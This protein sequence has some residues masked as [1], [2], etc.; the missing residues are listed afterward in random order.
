[1]FGFGGEA[2][3]AG[4]PYLDWW[5]VETPHFRVH[6]YRGLEPIADD[7]ATIA[8][9]IHARLAPDLGWSP[10][11]VTEIV[12]TDDTDDA[13]GSATALPY[14][15]IRLYVTAPDDLS[16]LGDYDDWYLELVTHEYTHILH[17]DDITGLPAIVNS[18]LGKTVAPNQAQPRWI[19]EGLA[20][21]EESRHTGGGR[22]RSSI[23]DMYLR[24]DVLEHNVAPLDQV[25]NLPRRW[26][27]GNLWYLYG[28][29]FLTWIADTYGEGAMKLIAHDYGSFL[30]PYGVNRS[31][32][33]ATGR[34]YV[35]LYDGWKAWLERHYAEQIAAAEKLGLREGVRLTHHGQTVGRPR[36]I[37]P[38]ARAQPNRDEVLFFRDDGHS[39]AGFHR[40]PLA[41][42]RLA[43][44]EEDE[45]LV[46]R[47]SGMGSASFEPSGGIVFNTTAVTSRI[48]AYNDLFRL[49]P[50]AAAPSGFEPELARLT[51]GERA[52]DPDV[53]PDGRQ[54]VFTENH[55]GT[56][57]LV[58]GRRTPDGGIEGKHALV[59]SA[60]F[61][62][63]YTPRFSPDGRKVA[64]SAWSAGGFRDVRVVDV[65]T[66][67]FAELTHDRALDIE[68]VFS[69]DGRYLFFTSDRAFGI[70]NVF[71]WDTE[72]GT[73]RQVTNVKTGAFMPEPSPDGKVLLYVGYGSGGYDLYA[74]PL[75]PATWLEPPP[76]VDTR[77]SVHSPP[78]NP[79]SSRHPYNPLPSLRPRSFL[80]SV[81][82][83]TFGTA[84][85]IQTTAAD[86][87]GLHSFAATL[88]TESEQPDPQL[89]LTYFYNRLP[90]DYRATF[91]RSL[92]PRAGFRYG[93]QQPVYV[94]QSLGV[95][96]GIGY[97]L[98]GPLGYDT[99]AF[100]LTYTI[101][102]FD[103][104][105]PMTRSADPSALV[106]IVPP[107]GYIGSVHLGWSYSNAERYLWS[108]GPERGFT[109]SF[110][111]DIADR[112]LASEYTLY[113]V[114]FTAGGYVPMPW[115]RHHT[116][117]LHAAAS[118]ASGDYPRRGLY[119][120]GG[121]LDTPIVD[122]YTNQ[123]FQSAFV[124]R[125]YA[126][127]AFIGSQYHLYKAEYRFPIVNVERGLST[128][129]GF[130]GRVSGALFADYGGA[131][132]TL[133]T[134]HWRD[135]LHL[136]VGAEVWTELTFGY[137]LTTMLRVGY[138]HGVKDPAAIPG[139]Q[140][141]VVVA[142][143]F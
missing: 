78:K 108:V 100:A 122:Q 54:I 135:Q 55:R 37:P 38:S 95:A 27:Q 106:T 9:G 94:E 34:T 112:S 119:Y 116:L 117:A 72:N 74:M 23:F 140:T 58:I 125:G 90:F 134:L 107:R 13:N 3:A 56:T 8:E 138:A 17:T 123:I 101:A 131:F 20:V 113:T 130:V 21:L 109:L 65:A 11:E 69:P 62:Q 53:S 141:Y 93:D 45:E 36:W 47:S 31:I 2:R 10:S 33:R 98:P 80:P 124:L 73:L 127:V 79:I 22:N 91:F 39:R 92:A 102:R 30:V 76:Y 121:F 88:T 115:A 126:P 49:P 114:G 50:R 5:T 136:G 51:H 67:R 43:A 6:Y 28:S 81:G 84:I 71:A 103:G 96:N 14:N 48:Y 66:G 4:N 133:D 19:L 42:G 120:T 105:L 29:R 25:S 52:Q 99:N 35:E 57:T 83:G 40:L 15:T 89:W 18:I 70:P 97:Q 137:F 68:P 12:L 118:M 46:V 1:M 59:P 143:P 60:R 16:P 132:D 77:P 86:A 64:Y 82:P 85:Q 111:T 128:L 129:P 7:I 142:A 44:N 110:G 75:D 63:A 26:P 139:G 24:A 32:R 87:V 104:D 41:P 61:E